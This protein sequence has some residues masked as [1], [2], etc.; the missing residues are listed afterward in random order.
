MNTDLREHK[1]LTPEDARR[2]KWGWVAVL[3]AWFAVD[4]LAWTY[5]HPVWEVANLIGLWTVGIGFGLLEIFGA[6]S[7]VRGWQT[8]DRQR[9]GQP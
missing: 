9:R 2:G 3:V 5:W 6:G 7:W 4:F 1:W 8:R